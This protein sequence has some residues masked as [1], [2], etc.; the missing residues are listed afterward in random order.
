MYG[1]SVQ[2]CHSLFLS[3]LSDVGLPWVPRVGSVE[4]MGLRRSALQDFRTIAICMSF[5]AGHL[6]REPSATFLKARP[7]RFLHR[8]KK[9]SLV[10][11]CQGPVQTGSKYMDFWHQHN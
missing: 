4:G 10:G 11:Q 7:V 5:T 8:R 9:D 6:A 1:L 3:D 2:G